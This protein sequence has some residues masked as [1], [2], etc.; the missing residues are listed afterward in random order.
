MFRRDAFVRVPPSPEVLALLHAEYERYRKKSRKPLS[1]KR[2]LK[3]IGFDDPTAGFPGGDAGA[4]RVPSEHAKLVEVPSRV[5]TG[6]VQVIVLLVDFPDKPGHRP[7]SEYEDML[8]SK[9]TFQTGSL[10]DFYREVSLGQVDVT[11]TVH[12][13]L[14]MPK[15]YAYYVDDQSGTGGYPHNVQKLAEDAI[16]AAKKKKVRFPAAL[17]NFNDGAVTA[18]VIVHAGKGAEVMASIPAQNAAIWSHKADMHKPVSVGNDLAVTNYL[19]V[20]EDCHMGVCAHELGHLLFQWDDFYDPNYA[21]DGSEWDGAGVW[22]LMAGGSW[23]NGGITPAHPAGL[24]KAQHRWVEI[25]EVTETTLGLIIPPYTKTAGTVVRVRSH[26]FSHTQCL[27]L[28]NRQRVGFDRALPGTGLLVWR[29]DT[30]K[31][32]L[33]PT[34]PAMLLVQADGRHDLEVPDDGDEGDA[35]DPFPGSAAITS[36]GD[37]GPLSTSFPHRRS[38]VSLENISVDGH[39]NIRVD[40]KIA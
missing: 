12:G 38:G 25:A 6:N 15:K 8:F 33:A 26:A 40:V 22:D 20:P 21:E 28:E 37:T 30:A 14:R 39:R 4:R 13:W 19:T 36:L 10:R 5:V 31:E 29:V 9:R 34:R 17:D 32:Q 11:G 3:K 7:A 1:F 18:F 27:I 24:H 16:A 35:G 23:N 2:W